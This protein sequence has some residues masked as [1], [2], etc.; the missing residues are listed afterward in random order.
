MPQLLGF[1]SSVVTIY[2]M[3]VFVRIML[4]WFSWMGRSRLQDVLARITDP[5]LNWFRRFPLRIGHIDLSPILALAVLSFAN[6][7]FITFAHHQTISIG[8]ILAMVVQMAWG[9]ISFILVFLMI[10][11]ALRLT[12][13]LARFNMYNPL[14][15]IVDAI[16][17][18]VSYKI[19]R[20]LFKNRIV[21][22]T[23]SC[24]ISIACLGFIFLVLRFIM[25]LLS[26]A[27]AGLPI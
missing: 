8:I 4:S 18:P 21:A 23:S 12:A 19:N 9:V 3:I 2:M 14:W 25:I 6:R 17:Q 16:Y 26:N 22:F 13:S 10:V 1:L 7:L 15:R 5:Y 11:F 27:L 20:T 24:L